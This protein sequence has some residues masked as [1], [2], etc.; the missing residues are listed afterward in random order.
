MIGINI[1]SW[2]FLNVL[3]SEKQLLL[4]EVALKREYLK[5]LLSVTPLYWTER[6]CLSCC[7]FIDQSL[8][9][10]IYRSVDRRHHYHMNTAFNYRFFWHDLVVTESPTLKR[11]ECF[12][13]LCF[14]A[15]IF[16]IFCKKMQ[17][18]AKKCT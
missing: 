18:F 6:G 14:L 3:L 12:Q 1:V 16:A 10:W 2:I 5:V 4:N 9:V 17:V 8:L 11:D 13:K 15:H 7:K